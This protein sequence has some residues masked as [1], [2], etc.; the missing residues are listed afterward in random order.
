MR[1]TNIQLSLQNINKPI[2]CLWYSYSLKAGP[3]FLVN[4]ILGGR[5]EKIK[6]NVGLETKRL[7]LLI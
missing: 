5:S 3:R 6:I 1:K 7:R 2:F 4:L